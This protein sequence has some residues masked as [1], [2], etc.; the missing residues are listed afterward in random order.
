MC[1]SVIWKLS[2]WAPDLDHPHICSETY[3]QAF[4]L[5]IQTQLQVVYFENEY[6]KE[7][8]NSLILAKK[9]KNNSKS[10]LSMYAC[11]YVCIYIYRKERSACNLAG[12][13]FIL[14]RFKYVTNF[15]ENN[16]EIWWMCC[17]EKKPD[18]PWWKFAKKQVSWIKYVWAWIYRK[19]PIVE[20]GYAAAEAFVWVQMKLL[21]KEPQE[22]W[23]LWT[24]LSVWAATMS[25]ISPIKLIS[26]L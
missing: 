20:L 14:Q 1:P 19:M 10:Y 3:L 2:I 12:K 24:G 26:S 21:N 16:G 17:S 25:S 6:W 7:N 5:T 13:L 23:D 9:K 11:V 4:P 22:H 15:F 8:W 18:R